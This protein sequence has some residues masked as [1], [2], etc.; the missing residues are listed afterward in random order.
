[1]HC[2]ECGE[3]PTSS[4]RRRQ[5]RR[6]P[7]P[8]RRRF[9]RSTCRAQRGHV[10]RPVLAVAR[11]DASGRLL[12][13]DGP[14][15]VRLPRSRIRRFG[16]D[17]PILG[18]VIFVYGGSPFLLGAVREIRSRRPGMMLLIGMAITVAFLAS[19][20]TTLG[21]VRS[22]V[23]VGTG[24]ADHHHAARALDGDASHRPGAWGPG[25]ARRT[26][27]GRGGAGRGRR[28]RNRLAI[29]SRRRRHRVGATRWPGSCRRGDR[30][31]EV[32]VDESMVTGE[33][34]PVAKQAG[35]RVIAGTV[36]H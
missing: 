29:G 5:P 25:G 14:G 20:A 3:S 6:S 36:H 1:M 15:V 32:E 31:G 24:R 16:V 7:E 34:R 9:P 27:A 23:L 26:V 17:R 13:R 30:Q 2:Q 12:L 33:S 35:D 28:N 8:S 21:V 19:A 18:T 22:R 4:P 10:P 11:P